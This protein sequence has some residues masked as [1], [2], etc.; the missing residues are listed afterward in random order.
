MN[1]AKCN[2]YKAPITPHRECH[3]LTDLH[4][5]IVICVLS[6]NCIIG[7]FEEK[8]SCRFIDTTYIPQICC[9]SFLQRLVLFSRDTKCKQGCPQPK[10]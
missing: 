7:S 1:V 5:C 2:A 8:N 3:T 9:N 6:F 10:M 4:S